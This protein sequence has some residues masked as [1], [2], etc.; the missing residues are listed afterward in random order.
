MND[1]RVFGRV[2]I[3]AIVGPRRPVVHEEIHAEQHFLAARK[4]STDA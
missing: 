3:R 4:L 1:K 2:E